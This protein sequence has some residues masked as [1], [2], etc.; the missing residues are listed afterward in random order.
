MTDD[1]DRAKDEGKFDEKTGLPIQDEAEVEKAKGKMAGMPIIFTIIFYAIGTAIAYGIY[2]WGDT[3]KYDA[4][5]ALAKE[6]DG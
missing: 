2:T 5:I 1:Y 3:T 6:Y 4:R